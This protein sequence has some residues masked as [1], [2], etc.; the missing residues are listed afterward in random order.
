MKNIMKTIPTA[1]M[2]KFRVD[3]ICWYTKHGN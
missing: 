3:L 1:T 2:L